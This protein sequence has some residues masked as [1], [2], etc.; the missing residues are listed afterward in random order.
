MNCPFCRIARGEL[1]AHLLFADD[2]VLAFLDAAPMAP[3]HTLVVP[4]TH[5]ERFTELSEE[6]A[7]RLFAVAVRISRALQE[8]LGASGFTVGINDGRVA[9]Q[10]V[11]HVHIH[12]VPRF[13]GDGGKSL[14][15]LLPYRPLRPD[16]DLAAQVRARLSLQES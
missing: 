15:A 10:G 12:I 16:P 1:A 7:S 2:E 13:P 14:H 11:P 4:K 9:G 6:Q 8:I 3:G 5:V